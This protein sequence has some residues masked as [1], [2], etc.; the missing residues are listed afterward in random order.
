MGFPGSGVGV[1]RVV[2]GVPLERRYLARLRRW[3]QRCR[4]WFRL[5]PE[6]R[7]FLDLVIAT[8]EGV[9]SRLLAVALEPILGRL[10]EALGGFRE[11][12]EA[13]FG[14]VAYLMLVRGRP[15]AL[16]LSQL[17]QGWGNRQ[18]SGWAEDVGFIRYLAA[19]ELN[20]PRIRG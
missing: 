8:L 16:R 15:M 7:R 1:L 20:R 10:L 9:R 2:C 18:A 3:A 13:L 14:R 12:V 5:E 11:A 4:A 17:A 19:M 6:D